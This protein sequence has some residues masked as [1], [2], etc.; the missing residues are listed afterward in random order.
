MCTDKDGKVV[1]DLDGEANM[2]ISYVGYQTVTETLGPGQDKTIRLATDAISMEAVVV[3]G[4]APAQT[5]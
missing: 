5:G 2:C 1:F 3:T 4:Q